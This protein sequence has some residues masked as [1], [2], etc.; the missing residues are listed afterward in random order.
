MWEIKNLCYLENCI[1]LS[2]KNLKITEKKGIIFEEYT[3]VTGSENIF[4]F[5]IW[6]KAYYYE[7]IIGLF[8]SNSVKA[9][10]A[11]NVIKSRLILLM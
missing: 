1:L 5:N 10:I 3:F 7:C 11:H 6:T 8:Q 9:F 2:L 4:H